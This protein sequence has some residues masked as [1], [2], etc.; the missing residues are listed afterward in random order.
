M[1]MNGYVDSIFNELFGLRQVSD[2]YHFVTARL[3]DYFEYTKNYG[4]DY[5]LYKGIALRNHITRFKP[6][7][8]RKI[9][10]NSINGSITLQRWSISEIL[11][12]PRFRQSEQ[13]FLNTISTKDYYQIARHAQIE[14]EQVERW[15]LD[16][17]NDL[18][19]RKCTEFELNQLRRIL[20][21]LDMIELFRCQYADTTSDEILDDTIERCNNLLKEKI[22]LFSLI[23]EDIQ[24]ICRTINFDVI[25]PIDQTTK[26]FI[27]LLEMLRQFARFV[28][29]EIG[30]FI[31]M[32]S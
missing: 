8:L 28:R 7:L 14:A 21:Q 12:L 15:L 2:S 20:Y 25:S 9:Y 22:N 16:L 6:V 24:V 30:E 11:D 3:T 10:G 26:K 29:G 31:P 18:L 17:N 32:F 1:G 13:A 5:C 4:S 19:D 23:H 27:N